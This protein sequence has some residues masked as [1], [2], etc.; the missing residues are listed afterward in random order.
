MTR[1]VKAVLCI[2]LVTSPTSI[3]L[4]KGSSVPVIIF[5]AYSS[6]AQN[7]RRYLA[8]TNSAYK[9]V[10]PFYTNAQ[11]DVLPVSWSPSGDMLA[12][13]LYDEFMSHPAQICVLTKS[14][15]LVS[16]MKDEPNI[17]AVINSGRYYYNVK[18]AADEKSIFFVID[19]FAN[20]YLMQGDVSTGRTI[21]TI[22]SGKNARSERS[23][24]YSWTN[25]LD[26]FILGAGDEARADVAGTITLINI[27]QSGSLSALQ[28]PKDKELVQPA[29]SLKGT[30]LSSSSPDSTVITQQGLWVACP[31]SPHD[32]YLP[33]FDQPLLDQ[34]AEEFILFDKSASKRLK[35]IT[36]SNA[37][38]LP[39]SCP[40]WNSDESLLYWE[41]GKN[42][43]FKYDFSSNKAHMLYQ[44]TSLPNFISPIVPS[45]LEDRLAYVSSVYPESTSII[46]VDKNGLIYTLGDAQL[47]T[48]FPLWMP[49]K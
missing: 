43:V 31:F 40:S 46:V 23:T 20:Y 33:A 44:T 36:Y 25:S 4:Q 12:I 35:T 28:V 22:Y 14:A 2:I 6:L 8:I 24:I 11:L 26:Y 30:P 29:P 5:Q 37:N 21:R 34:R 41:S 19:T 18:W 32:T 13:V 27:P 39:I 3:S 49:N 17:D 48:D 16:C 38:D 42:K 9:T 7:S 1:I 10:S 15:Q 47:T 45:N